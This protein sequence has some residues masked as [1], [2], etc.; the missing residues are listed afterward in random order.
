MARA[1]AA[2]EPRSARPR[3]RASLAQRNAR[4]GWFFVLP[5]L[6]GFVFIFLD[7][8]I[9]SLQISLSEI[10]MSAKGYSLLFI[11][12]AN[13]YEVFF[14]NPNFTWDLLGNI[15]A[16]FADVIVV[17][18][19]SLFIATILN[20]K[21]RGRALFRAIFFIPVILATGIIEK[22]EVSNLVMSSMNAAAALDTGGMQSSGVLDLSNIQAI[23]QNMYLSEGM[24]R[25]IMNVVNN[26]YDVVNRSGVQILIFLAGLQS[27]SPSI[28]ESASIEGATGWEAF[29]KITFPMISPILFVNMVYTIIDYFTRS[30]NPIMTMIEEAGYTGLASAMAWSY[31][32]AIGVVLA[33][34][35]AVCYR[36]IFYQQRTV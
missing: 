21:M 15:G 24:I 32:A 25:F 18:I 6:I 1:I 28:Y 3:R 29:W 36:L 22:A 16:M 34:V 31:F 14:E 11:G 13:Y 7:I 9:N 20:Q 2:K 23:L 33:V 8:L 17:L 10:Q 5:F 19:F 27:I 4:K 30:T 26:I 12:M 35:V